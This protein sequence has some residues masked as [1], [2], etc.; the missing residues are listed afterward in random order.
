MYEVQ[1]R[2]TPL[3]PDHFETYMEI[4]SKSYKQHYLHL[5]QNQDPTPYLQSSFSREVVQQEW[6]D[7]FTM[8]FLVV[9]GQSPAGIV[10]L[11]LDKNIPLLQG[12]ACLFLERIYLLREFSGSG[13]GSQVLKYVEELGR[14]RKKEVVCLETMQKGRALSFYQKYGFTIIGEKQLDYPDAVE[15]ER[16]MFILCKKL[17]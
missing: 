1:F 16:P 7:P 6:E 17:S 12:T 10:K 2:L 5:W 11:I 9:S 14:Q 4:G 13:L 15:S 3:T 8:L